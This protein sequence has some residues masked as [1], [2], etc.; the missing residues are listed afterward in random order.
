V[1][2]AGN[3]NISLSIGSAADLDWF[4]YNSSLTEVAR[5]YSV[6]NPEVG[7]YNAAAGRYYLRV[8]G[9]QGATSGYTL[10]V[11]G[12]LANSIV[13]A[14]KA[15]VAA[16]EAPLTFALQ[17]NRPNPFR[18]STAIHFA[19]ARPGRVDLRIFDLQGR[20][21]HSLVEKDLD[22]GRHVVEWRGVNDRGERAAP[23][24]YF[25]RLVTPGFSEMRK[26]LLL[27]E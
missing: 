17:Q 20:L 26:M 5:G 9:Y 18:A 22:A 25:Y 10:T 24:V 3:I 1:S 2:T 8:S 23:G 12:G 16:A 13:P 11:N 7:N 21:I 15:F 14:Q 4:L 27:Q 6:A 19:L